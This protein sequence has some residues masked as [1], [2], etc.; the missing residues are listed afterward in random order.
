MSNEQMSARKEEND[1]LKDLSVQNVRQW[2]NRS[3]RH[4]LKM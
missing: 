3:N 4:A 1:W 2:F